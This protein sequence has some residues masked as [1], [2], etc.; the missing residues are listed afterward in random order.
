MMLHFFS[1]LDDDD[2]IHHV[3]ELLATDHRFL[4]EDPDAS[5]PTEMFRSSFLVI[6]IGTTHLRDIAAFVDV[7]G[8][9]TRAMAAGEGGEG[10][11][12]IASAAVR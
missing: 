7:P 2:D 10:V 1:S 11:V 9:N 3:A 4:R 8:W 5:E 12:A 6:L